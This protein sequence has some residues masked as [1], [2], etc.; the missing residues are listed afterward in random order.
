VKLIVP[1]PE[2]KQ[3]IVFFESFYKLKKV[4][5]IA[6]SRSILEIEGTFRG[7]TFVRSN[8]YGDHVRAARGTHK[9]AEVNE[10][11][12]QSSSR[13]VYANLAAKII[14]DALDPY[15]ENFKGGL[16]WQRLLSQCRK[17][18]KSIGE[19]DFSMLEPVEV[20]DK[21]PLSRF[22]SV[23]PKVQ[24]DP[25]KHA[26]HVQLNYGQHPKPR[27]MKYVDGYRIGVI[28][29]FPDL[30]QKMAMTSVVYSP[31]IKMSSAYEKLDLILPVPTEATTYL[32]CV[33][34]EAYTGGSMCNQAL[35]K[36]MRIESA[37]KIQAVSDEL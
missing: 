7:M 10:A 22:L 34:V 9:P 13:L 18:L 14:K 4:V 29:I 28:G 24:Y 21:Y 16:L 26:L 15:R 25:D 1:E 6:K 12:Q 11:F 5:F 23:T 27:H 17:Q 35:N 2:L 36:G 32:L 20:H 19:I 37:G 31:V 3:E 33:K 8:V 30:E